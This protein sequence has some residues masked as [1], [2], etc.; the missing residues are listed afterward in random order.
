[1]TEMAATPSLRPAS[2]NMPW[3]WS[4]FLVAIFVFAN[5][6]SPS[7]SGKAPDL[8]EVMQTVEKGSALREAALLFLLLFALF[9]FMSKKH[10]R[11]RVNGL[12]GWS[13]LF[14]ISLALASP[15]WAEDPSY[16]SLTVRRS[17]VL[18]LLFLGALAT[19]ARF[20]R[21]Q[22]VAL[23]VCVCS[24]TLVISL[25]VE[26]SIGNFHPLDGTWR[27]SGMIH[28]VIQGWNCGLLAI[29]SL[30]LSAASPR[31]RGRLI[32]L[33][34]TAFLFLS[35]TRSR[36]P[37][38]TTILATVV[39]GCLMSIRMRKLIF[40]LTYALA[41]CAGCV[42][43]ALLVLGANLDRTA[44]NVAAMGRGH[45]TE[46]SLSTF[47]GR[48]ELW[49]QELSYARTR[50]VLGFGYNAFLNA[51]NLPA[52]SSAAGWAPTSAHSGYIGTLVGLGYVGVSSLVIVLVLALKR[53]LSQARGSPSAAFAAAVMIWLCCNLFFESAII[54][55]PTFPTFFCC[56]ILGSLAFGDSSAHRRFCQLPSPRQ[57]SYAETSPGC[58]E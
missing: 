18:L 22:A 53:S 46:S 44:L 38:V 55:E 15:V 39:L 28:P 7:R 57:F 24:L 36:T 45:D 10:W 34:L 20:S 49:D 16:P 21:I 42:W 14:Y 19:V 50:P 47:T 56:V 40:I 2:A 43:L 23:A 11:L 12:L 41:V 48:Q 54:M 17:G 29:A 51:S 5:S 3:R 27:F 35:L 31:S 58:R 30:A 33:A 6:L 13:M 1:M 52:V 37:L 8:D 26:I 32:F 9:T 25:V 4:L